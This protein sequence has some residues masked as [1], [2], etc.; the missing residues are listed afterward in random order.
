M[1]TR[2]EKVIETLDNINKA[3]EGDRNALVLTESGEANPDRAY[4]ELV[5]KVL[6]LLED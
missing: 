6:K 1:K 3:I 2:K 4:I 5:Q